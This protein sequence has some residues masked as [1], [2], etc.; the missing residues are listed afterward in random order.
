M[1]NYS[2]YSQGMETAPKVESWE[3]DYNVA[4]TKYIGKEYLKAKQLIELIKKKYEGQ[5]NPEMIQELEKKIRSRIG[6]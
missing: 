1:S 4:V 3:S 6:I 2:P 5:Y